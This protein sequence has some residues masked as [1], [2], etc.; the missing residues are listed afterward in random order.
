MDALAKLSTV[1]FDKTGTLTHGSFE[2]EAV[3]PETIDEKELLH[4][5]AHVER[6]STHP[7]AS[8]YAMRIPMRLTV[9]W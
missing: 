2:V 8:P 7:I 4:L 9:A 6:F 3:H 5:A 1:V